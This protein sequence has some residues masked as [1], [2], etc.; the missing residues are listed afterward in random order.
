M[1]KANLPGVN[2]ALTVM[3]LCLAV[4]DT[5]AQAPEDR[6][7]PAVDSALRIEDLIDRTRAQPQDAT[8]WTELGILYINENLLPEARS[9]FISALQAAP[10][11]PASH[12]NLAVCLARMEKWDEAQGPLQSY[13]SM[14]P[15]DV[16]GWALGGD[17]LAG[18]GNP[19]GAVDLWLKGAKLTE[20]PA[21]DR[22][23]LVTKA[24]GLLL[25]LDEADETEP[26]DSELFRAGAIFDARKDLVEGPD[27]AELRVRRDITWLELARRQQEDGALDQALKSWEHLRDSGSKN[28]AAWQQPIQELIDRD[29]LAE[30]KALS[31]DASEALPGSAI[32]EYLNGRIADAEGNP[33]AA[34]RAYRKAADIDPDLPGVWPALGES[35]AKAGDS[36]GA[37]D[38]LAEAVKRGQGG[39]AAAYNM[40][41]VLSQKQQFKQAIPYLE[42]AVEADPANRDAFRALGTAYRKENRFRD[43]AGAYQTILDS[44]G[45][46]AR[47]LYQ[48]AYCEA[49]A[50]DHGK[51][52]AH[53]EM[54]TALDPS[55]V[56]AFYG[57]G[58]AQSKNDRQDAAIA[59]YRS[60][61]ELKP[62]FHGASFGWALA[63]QKKGD[64]EGAI[65]RYEL[66]LELKETYSSYVNMAICY[67]NLGDEETSNEYYAL[68]N[69]LKKKG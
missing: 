42:D 20:I 21:A 8:A 69:E 52:A 54:V 32:T 49:K 58:N 51:A 44:F 22:T 13:R 18:T 65:E 2:L 5:R 17:A 37:S 57:L 12:L 63:L 48:L 33:S 15:E 3:A 30:A 46:D 67:Q 24:T 26:T 66:T 19:E 45:P 47:D 53:Y 10:T 25:H 1:K 11:E 35:L 41:V 39:A 55:N 43:A 40:G 14:V 36:K 29:R 28:H 34:A 6:T 9:A 68:A 60:A 56:N 23:L 4:A 64:F 59:A 31:R 61:L 50:G 62:D 38:A 16:R 27:G 7:E